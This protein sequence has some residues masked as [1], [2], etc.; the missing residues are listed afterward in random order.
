MMEADCGSTIVSLLTTMAA[1]AGAT[2]SLRGIYT[3]DGA[4]AGLSISSV[5]ATLAC[6]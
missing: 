6:Y 4:L 2:A 1:M 3:V 5:V